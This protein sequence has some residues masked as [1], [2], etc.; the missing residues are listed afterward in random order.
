MTVLVSR[1]TQQ[2]QPFFAR[3]ALWDD[4][5]ADESAALIA[6]AGEFVTFRLGEDLVVEGDRPRRSILLTEG[7]ACRYRL[8]DDGSRQI[9]SLN[10]PGDF[11]D[12][13][14][15]LLKE[16]DHSVGALSACGAIAFPHQNLVRLTEQYPHL[17]RLLWLLTLIEGSGQREWLVGF[18]RLS[19]P[20]RTAH[21]LCETYLRLRTVGLAAD[22]RFTF[23]ITQAALADAVGIS[24]VH[25]NRVLQELRQ[26]GL[27]DWERGLVT[28]H[29]WPEFVAFAKFDSHYLH[30]VN[31]Q[32]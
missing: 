23:P 6:A 30:M 27:I 32:R 22:F 25:I 14:S 20:E 3:L 28:I 19:A 10:L 1:T 11:V 2:L 26:A 7:F 18:G 24:A 13:H 21:L 29:D 5:G 4:L 15:F 12:L 31:E 17:T 16:M 8:Q 9:I